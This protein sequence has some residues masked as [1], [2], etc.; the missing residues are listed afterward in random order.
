MLQAKCALYA[1]ESAH[2]AQWGYSYEAYYG[3][4]GQEAAEGEQPCGSADG[5]S[6][7]T[8]GLAAPASEVFTASSEASDEHLLAQQQQR[9]SYQHQHGK[10]HE[11]R[12]GKPSWHSRS[13]LHPAASAQTRPQESYDSAFPT[14]GPNATAAAAPVRRWTPAAATRKLRVDAPEWAPGAPTESFASLTLKAKQAAAAVAAAGA[15]AASL[16]REQG[17]TADRSSD[18]P[19]AKERKA[20]RSKEKR[21]RRPEA[22]EPVQASSEMAEGAAAKT[23]RNILLAGQ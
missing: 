11:Q 9:R 7:P 10:R 2:I 15:A 18:A 8:Q 13:E 19:P 1:Y 22:C 16:E 20:Q 3:T 23:W 21:Q 17:D 14:L 5:S 4:D 6:S 12:G